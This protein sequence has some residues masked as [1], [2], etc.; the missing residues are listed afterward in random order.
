MSEQHRTPGPKPAL[1]PGKTPRPS[2]PQPDS[3]GG[4][5]GAGR[6]KRGG[7]TGRGTGKRA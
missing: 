1:T 2:A 7:V 3:H 6:G 4:A 5:G